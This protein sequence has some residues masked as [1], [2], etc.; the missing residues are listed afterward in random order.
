VRDGGSGSTRDWGFVTRAL[1][2]GAV[3]L[4]VAGCAGRAIQP[5]STQVGIA[6]WYGPGFH[7]KQTASGEVYDQFGLTAAHPTWPLGTRARVTN[8][9]NGRAVEV[10]INDRGPFVDD[11]VVDL[12]YGAA[13]AIGL[14][15]NGTSSVRVEPLPSHGAPIGSVHFAVQL[16]SF[17]DHLRAVSFR[18]QIARTSA[19]RT[20]SPERGSIYVLTT[21]MERPVYRVRIGPYPERHMARERAESLARAG[22]SPIIVEEVR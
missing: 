2:A 4:T 18:D 19:L 10:R 15:R 13:H 6:S 7:G 9:E 3:V 1:L 5:P 14:V 11:R 8:L 21:V 20:A 16:A 12:S 17:S 22:F